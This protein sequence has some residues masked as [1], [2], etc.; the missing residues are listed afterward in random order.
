[1]AALIV[2]RRSDSKLCV[3]LASG[4][5]SS[6]ELQRVHLAARVNQLKGSERGRHLP[7]PHRHR[8]SPIVPVSTLK[9]AAS[10]SSSCDEPPTSTVWSHSSGMESTLTGV[11][12]PERSRGG[13]RR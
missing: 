13:A 4:R 7:R 2:A 12:R 9:N 8:R 6:G 11:S 1:M 3:T 5:E 10:S